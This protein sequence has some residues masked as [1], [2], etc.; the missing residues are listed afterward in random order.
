MAASRDGA[1]VVRANDAVARR[2]AVQQLEEVRRLEKGAPATG[3]QA[4]IDKQ[5][6][7]RFKLEPAVL[8]LIAKLKEAK[9]KLEAV[10]KDGIKPGDPTELAAQKQLEELTTAYN[11]AWESKSR[12]YR[13]Q[14]E[15]ATG[16]IL[17]S[18]FARPN[19][20]SGS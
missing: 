13:E 3:E 11:Q 16:P 10:R 1:S 9:Q 20:G 15:E 7:D 5:V 18:N 4:R 17:S 2:Y 6:D 8:D 19:T 12:I 14:I